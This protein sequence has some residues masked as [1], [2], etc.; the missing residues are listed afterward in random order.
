MPSISLR[1]QLKVFKYG[2]FYFKC[3]KTVSI[4]KISNI[5]KVLIGTNT[6]PGSLVKVKYGT[7]KE[8]LEAQIIA[9]EGELHVIFVM[10]SG[11]LCNILTTI[12]FF[13]DDVQKLREVESQFLSDSEN[14]HLFEEEEK[15]ENEE[16]KGEG[17]N[18]KEYE[19]E[20]KKP[21]KEPRKRKKESTAGDNTKP[22]KAKKDEK[23]PTDRRA[24]AKTAR[25]Q[26][27]KTAKKPATVICRYSP[28]KDASVEEKKTEIPSGDLMND[29]FVVSLPGSPLSSSTSHH[30]TTPKRS[31]RSPSPLSS[32]FHYSPLPSLPGSPF[33]HD[34]FSPPTPRRY[35][36]Q[37]QLTQFD[38]VEA[39]IGELEKRLVSY[40]DRK[41]DELFSFLHT[42]IHTPLPN[43]HATNPHTLPQTAT[44]SNTHVLAE[45]QFQTPEHHFP[46]QGNTHIFTATEDS[47]CLSSPDNSEL[48]NER[49]I[50]IRN[51]ASSK[52]NFGVR[53]IRELFQSSE[54]LGRNVEGVRGKKALDPIRIQKIKSLMMQFYPVPPMEQESAWRDC[55]KAID[56]FLRKNKT[57]KN[58]NMY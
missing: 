36:V 7:L 12:F 28:G 56:S 41:F 45:Q 18:E 30:T 24:A 29:T 6:K 57:P 27:A 58:K 50:I 20:A 21:V 4:V 32:S 40:V 9:V 53:L 49:L 14:R 43:F 22:K 35:R 37:R 19:E 13:V 1:N 34:D 11:Q 15:G 44:Q 46:Q 10:I 54:L 55:R 16:E 42:R 3:D 8:P 2:L 23:T 38:P 47:G 17:E 33:F 31:M 48:S 39:A 26:P 52:M 25:P 5:C 51:Q